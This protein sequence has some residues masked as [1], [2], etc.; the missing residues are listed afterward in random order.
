[1]KPLWLA[2]LLPMLTLSLGHGEGE[3]RE[4]FKSEGTLLDTDDVCDFDYHHQYKYTVYVDPSAATKDCDPPR[5]QEDVTCPDI[6]TALDMQFH[7]DSTAFV[8]SS[9]PNVTHTLKPSSKNFLRNLSGVG[10]FGESSSNLAH[11][12]CEDGAGLAFWNVDGIRLQNVEFS[13]C[14]A[15]RN[16]TSKN[17][18]KQADNHFTL[19]KIMVGLYFYNGTDVTM[20]H[21]TVQH[22]ANALGVLMYDTNGTVNIF[23]SN[24]VNNSMPD[25]ITNT[26]ATGCGGFNVE[27]SYCVPGDEECGPSNRQLTHITDSSYMFSN[28]TFIN[29]SAITGNAARLVM[30]YNDHIGFGKG[31]GLAIFFVSNATGNTFQVSG[32]SFEGNEAVW[33]GG[34]YVL[35]GNTSI[36]NT[37]SVDTTTFDNN[38]C[39]PSTGS[40]G[41]LRVYSAMNFRDSSLV[42][43]H[44]KGNRMA[45]SA[46]TFTNNEALQGGAIAFSPTYQ[47][48]LVKDQTTHLSI[49]ASSFSAN[50]A[51]MG[52]AIHAE[53][54]PFFVFGTI[55]NVAIRD[56][57][58]ENN[59]I[60]YIRG[61]SNY[62]MGIGTVY[63]S[64]VPLNFSSRVEFSDN[65]GSALALTS[66]YA[67]FYNSNATFVGNRGDTG[68]A[69]AFLGS[70]YAIV[71]ESTN[72]HFERN[73]ARKGGAIYNLLTGQ[74]VVR[75]SIACFILNSDP[76]EKR[77]KWKAS[78]TFV[79]NTSINNTRN[80]IYTTSAFPCAR[81][82]IDDTRELSKTLL[83]CNNPNWKFVDSNCINEIQTEGNLYKLASEKVPISSIPGMGFDLPVQVYDDLGHN[84]TNSTGYTTTVSPMV[85]NESTATVAQV[86]PKFS[87][88]SDNYVSIEGQENTKVKL[89]LQSTGSR[90]HYLQMEVD[91]LDCPPGFH[92]ETTMSVSGKSLGK[93]TC[94]SAFSFGKSLNCSIEDFE[95]SIPWNFWI[96]PD[97]TGLRKGELVM[98]EVPNLYS[99]QESEMVYYRVLPKSNDELNDVVCGRKRRTG[100][101]CGKCMA[102]YSTSVNSFDYIC[103]RCDDT[104]NLVKNVFLFIL[105]A[106]LPYIILLGAI[107]LFNLKLTSSA[108]NGFILYAQMMSV[109]IFDIN[110]SS[111]LTFH[112]DRLH[113]AYLFVYGVFDFNSLATIMKPFCIH[114]NWTTLDVL[115]LEY[116]LAGLPIILILLMR[117]V[118]RFKSIRFM[119]CRSRKLSVQAS[120]MP[121]TQKK[122]TKENDLIHT[123][124]AFILLSYTKVTLV[125]MKI[126][127]MQDLFDRKGTYI[128]SPRV[129][130][131]GHLSFFSREFF[132][133]YGA[134]A[135]IMLIIVLIPPLF[136]LGMPQL[137]NRILDTKKFPC[138]ERLW[139][140]VTIKHYLD[141]FQGFY[142]EELYCRIFAGLYFVFRLIILILYVTTSNYL[143]TY[144]WQQFFIVLMIV[145]LAICQPYEDRIYNIL[146]ILIFLNLA[147]V[148]MISSYV[149][150]SS[151]TV[152]GLKE[153]VAV[154]IYVL[155]YILLWLPLVYMLSYVGYKILDKLG[156]TQR[157]NFCK[158]S[159]QTVYFD[160][161][162]SDAGQSTQSESRDEEDYQDS[163]SGTALTDSALFSRAEFRPPVKKPTRSLVAVTQHTVKVEAMSGNSVRWGES[164][165]KTTGN[166]YV[167]T[168]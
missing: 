119:C 82:Y 60:Q 104:T 35:F 111:R 3:A 114:K 67:D 113:K 128:N 161:S 143:N 84:I 56:C 142:K 158:K 73:F 30:H 8:L 74:G 15:L 4:K 75:S 99:E 110:G 13:S 28:C 32:C 123:L 90:P 33:G 24:F 107:A 6:N 149:Y 153:N 129:Y 102:N 106:Y 140:T 166:G 7:G 164:S 21:V 25:D 145:L 48:S 148:N 14:G 131:A 88:T 135:I 1:M 38:K 53:L 61:V 10:F 146:D 9:G 100:A 23:H 83:F 101:L 130:L 168:Y 133:P 108:T 85:T 150:T 66:T 93:C 43:S 70:S 76:F 152:S 98:G 154:G 40:G 160:I 159:K 65:F 157:F 96:G 86:D 81:G 46:S 50:H 136:L 126:L 55:N 19:I 2:L 120:P 124:V 79:N 117:F 139:P 29:N 62:T 162:A 45:V 69:I 26:N 155:Q 122:N 103:T 118:I 11:V 115:C 37:V 116:T 112:T 91:L 156:I 44:V 42:N 134:I 121:D 20:C 54:N 52:A 137:I 94:K 58:F 39:F 78:F 125:S 167:D 57:V 141:A 27:F 22:S 16:T 5:D 63:T 77:S 144:I 31:G 64:Q 95:A 34:M 47:T 49:T 12:V 132:V 36:G 147:M 87:L 109:D 138:C 71:D 89:E 105:F 72:M 68:G 92:F 80:S 151:L 59:S 163:E 17:F 41:A 127:A 51:Q 165:P 18:T 97:P